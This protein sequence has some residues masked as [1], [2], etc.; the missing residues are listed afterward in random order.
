MKNNNIPNMGLLQVRDHKRI[1]QIYE[2]RE[3]SIFF[4]L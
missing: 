1:Q 4:Q 3:L 2:K